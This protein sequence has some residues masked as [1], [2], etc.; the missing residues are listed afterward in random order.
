MRV[1]NCLFILQAR[2]KVYPKVTTDNRVG[3]GPSKVHDRGVLDWCLL[4]FGVDVLAC[5]M[6]HWRR[7]HLPL[8]S[9]DFDRPYKS[10][11]V[12]HLQW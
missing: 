3:S 5:K 11:G 9:F 2:L 6:Y 7:D 1:C 12:Y 8:Q 4:D 10:S